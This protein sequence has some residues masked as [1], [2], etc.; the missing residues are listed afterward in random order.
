MSN[1]GARSHFHN[2]A[3]TRARP[4]TQPGWCAAALLAAALSVADARA[5]AVPRPEAL[6]K[7]RQSAFQVIAW[8]TGRIKSALA[9]EYDAHQVR[10]A[11]NALAAVAGAGLADLFA[12]NTAGS[13]GWRATTAGGAVF[14]DTARFR[15]LSDEFARDTA[16]LARLA[17]GGDRK[18]VGAQFEKVAKRCKG[19]HDRYRETD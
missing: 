18:A 10:S 5:Q 16:E 14:S 9:G 1:P 2:R 4:R 6:V 19:C 11:A 12:P 8:N 3:V 13:K 15:A 7:W 17:A